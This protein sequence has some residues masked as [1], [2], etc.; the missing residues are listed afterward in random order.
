MVP[1]FRGERALEDG[2]EGV[3]SAVLASAGEGVEIIGL[4]EV[5]QSGSLSL[6]CFESMGSSCSSVG[7]A[8]HACARSAVA[9]LA[10]AAPSRTCCSLAPLSAAVVAHATVSPLHD[11]RRS[12]CS[13]GPTARRGTKGGVSSPAKDLH[14]VSEVYTGV[15]CRPAGQ[16]REQ[17]VVPSPGPRPG[18]GGS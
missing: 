11:A 5:F 10:S 1:A 3:R 17:V 2:I 6:I 4:R 16:G 18:P 12:V 15:K 13:Q 9:A 14:L 7:V 8:A